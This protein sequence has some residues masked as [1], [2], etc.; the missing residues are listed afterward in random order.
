M[1]LE[2]KEV[3]THFDTLHSLVS[4]IDR[5][6]YVAPLQWI[7][8]VAHSRESELHAERSLQS[9]TH[10]AV[11]QSLTWSENDDRE[12]DDSIPVAQIRV[13]IARDHCKIFINTS[14]DSLHQRGW[15]TDAWE[16]PISRAYDKS[17]ILYSISRSLL[18]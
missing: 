2:E 5:K 16:A 11:L 9:I 15:R 7:S 18:W 12:I 3:C 14:W 1:Q 13:S 10:K 6:Q 17:M 4:T 8:I